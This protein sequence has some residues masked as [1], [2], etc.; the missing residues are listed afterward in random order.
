MVPRVTLR[1]DHSL[2]RPVSR[3]PAVEATHLEGLTTV[4]L[5]GPKRHTERHVFDSVPIGV[6]LELVQRLGVETL[7]IP[8]AS[9][10]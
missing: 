7:R 3:R 5:A 2:G 9:D 10:R 1:Q 4:G 6:H 8:V